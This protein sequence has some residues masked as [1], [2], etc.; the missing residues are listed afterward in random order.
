MAQAALYV[1][2]NDQSS[3]SS[4]AAAA[5]YFLPCAIVLKGLGIS[6]AD[7]N[8]KTVTVDAAFLRR[9]VSELARHQ[10]FDPE[11]YASHY[12]DIEGACLAGEISS[13]Q[14]HFVQT[15]Y[16]EGRFPSALPFDP[17][18]Y[19]SHYKDLAKSYAAGDVQGLRT[20][21]FTT[22]YLEGRAGTAS[23]LDEAERWRL[24]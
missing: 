16:L 20:H 19:H 5:Q 8:R 9:V 6:E 1:S 3:S 14:S 10:R 21:F 23:T 13:M 24:Y 18:W 2:A 7:L 17:V 11:F 22:G 15:G 12:P 4:D